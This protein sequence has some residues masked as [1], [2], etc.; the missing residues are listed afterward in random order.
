M[1]RM[2]DPATVRI[3]NYLIINILINSFFI[4]FNTVINIIKEVKNLQN[5]ILNVR[6]IGF[7]LV[8]TRF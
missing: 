5:S 1:R 3:E 8:F 2:S 6:Y 4:Y 7:F